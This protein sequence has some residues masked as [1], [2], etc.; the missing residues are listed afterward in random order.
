MALNKQIKILF[1]LCYFLNISCINK[2]KNLS[3][4]QKTAAQILG[5]PEYLAISYGGYRT[6]SREIQPSLE[7]LKEDLKI[8]Y[9]MGIRIT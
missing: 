6:T 3:L 1:V 9:A 7:A 2:T 4:K 8:M 5:N